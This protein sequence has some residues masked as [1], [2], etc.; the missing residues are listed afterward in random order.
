MATRLIEKVLVAN[1]GEIACRVFKTAKKLGISTVAVYSEADKNSLHT[2]LADHSFYIGQAA[3]TESYLNKQKIIDTALKS[4]S[5]AVH[6]GY[7]F[8]SEN[9]DFA[10]MCTKNDVV[11]V[12][13][14]A[15]AIKAMGSKSESK[16]IMVNAEVPVVP[17][18]HQDSQ[19]IELLRA[20]AEKIGY[21]VLIKAVMGGGGKG[22]KLAQTSSEFLTQLESA[23]N[24]SLKAFGDDRVILE[25]Y[26]INPRHI[27]VQVFADT[28]GNAVYLFERDCSV[29]RRHQ[30]VIEEAPS[31]ITEEKR[32]SMGKTATQAALAVGYVGAGTV[33]FIFDLDSNKHYFMEMNT[34]LQVEHPISE[35][36]TGLDFVEWQLL[37]ASG[38]PL[39]KKQN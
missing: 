6:P 21:P 28:L 35:M 34:R 38:F 36:I 8:L 5:Q 30:K 19:D 18:Y 39:P 13:P 16:K 20:E 11:F 17:G 2:S 15:S 22:M 3:P 33:E 27:E 26:I 12:G 14:P 4:K 23:K 29:Q 1:R 37:V 31:Y 9:A 32:S 10:E 7:G 24:E 25:K